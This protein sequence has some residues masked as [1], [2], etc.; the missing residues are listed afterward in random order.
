[1]L[2]ETGDYKLLKRKQQGLCWKCGTNIKDV[3]RFKCPFCGNEHD[4]EI[5]QLYID[6]GLRQQKL[7]ELGDG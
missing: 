5:T 1:M 3:P 7:R 6:I 2:L 4:T